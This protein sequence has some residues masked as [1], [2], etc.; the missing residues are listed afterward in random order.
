MTKYNCCIAQ[1]R[2]VPGANSIKQCVEKPC[3]EVLGC[4]HSSGFCES[5]WELDTYCTNP[6]KS[7]RYTHSCRKDGDFLFTGRHREQTSSNGYKLHEER[8]HLIFIHW[9]KF[10]FTVRTIT[11]WKIIPRDRVEPPQLEAFKMQ[12]DWVTIFPIKKLD[13]MIFGVPFQSGLDIHVQKVSYVS[14]WDC[15]ASLT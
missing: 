1:L 10:F 12:L 15:D 6:V 2:N 3:V 8:F 5:K 11:H 9:K 7:Y 13:Q 14:T 4:A